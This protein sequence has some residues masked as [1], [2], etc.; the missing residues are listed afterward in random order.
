MSSLRLLMTN[1]SDSEDDSSNDGDEVKRKKIKSLKYDKVEELKTNTVDLNKDIDNELNKKEDSLSSSSSSPKASAIGLHKSA[2]QPDQIN[3]EVD[4]QD[5]LGDDFFVVNKNGN[6]DEELDDTIDSEPSIIDVDN[7]EPDDANVN[8][9][10]LNEKLL[11]SRYSPK[12]F[13]RLLIGVD[14][15]HIRIPD[16][17]KDK[18]CSTELIDKINHLHNL[19]KQGRNLIE[20]LYQRRDLRNPSICDQMI[21]LCGI[22]EFGTNLPSEIFDPTRFRKPDQSDDQSDDQKEDH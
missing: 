19:M 11:D 13:H 3:Q 4:Y 1:Y 5:Y 21:R 7:N 15:E 12:S 20:E 10:N 16:A 14:E 6:D 2:E 17:P 18:E 8:N 22:D 9:E